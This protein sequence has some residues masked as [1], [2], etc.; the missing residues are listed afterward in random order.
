MLLLLLIGSRA[1]SPSAAMRPVMVGSGVRLCCRN[2]CRLRWK[3]QKVYGKWWWVG[4]LFVLV[5]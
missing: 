5:M 1:G 3:K 2:T 4:K